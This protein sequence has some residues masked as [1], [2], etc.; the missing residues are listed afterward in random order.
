MFVFNDPTGFR[1]LYYTLKENNRLHFSEH[2][3]RRPAEK[4]CLWT[5]LQMIMIGVFSDHLLAGTHL[6]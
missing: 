6:A 5:M 2:L 3:A 4:T 1:N